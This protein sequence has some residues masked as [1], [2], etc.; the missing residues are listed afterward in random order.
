MISDPDFVPE[1]SLKG[2]TLNSITIGWSNPSEEMRDHVHYYMLIVQDNT[3]TKEAIHPGGAMNLY[4]FQDLLSA[5]TYRFKVAACSYYTKQCGRWSKEAN[6]TTMDGKSGPPQNVSLVCRFDNISR[7]SFVYVTW[8]PPLHPNGQIMDYN[9]ILEGVATFKNESGLVQNVTEIPQVKR[10]KAKSHSTRFDIIPANTNY[11][12]RVS[13]VTRGK[14]P[15]DEKIRHCR[16]PPTIPDKSKL[17]HFFWSKVEEQGRWLFKLLLPRITERNGPIC[18]YRVFLVKLEP[19]Q[20]V[21]DLP[22]P[23]EFFPISSYEEVHHSKKGGA[24]VAEMFESSTLMSEV[25]LGDGHSQNVNSTACSHCVGLRPKEHSIKSTAVPVTTNQIPTAPSTSLSGTPEN[26]FPPSISPSVDYISGITF[27]SSPEPIRIRR[28]EST[29][30][31]VPIPALI[32]HNIP[33]VSVPPLHATTE[34]MAE[35]FPVFDGQL[36]MSN[37]YTGFVEVIVYGPEQTLLPAYS[38]YF[39]ALNPGPQ[40]FHAAEQSQVLAL[41]LQ[42]LCALILIVLVL[43]LSLCLLQRYTKQVAEAQGVEMTLTNSF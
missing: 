15:G 8:T 4:L 13:G 23:E 10:V 11:T 35:Q 38:G 21:A 41:V 26:I 22:T 37:N 42:V 25:F 34:S 27:E 24:Y 6:G 28:A 19:Q 30:A 3:T 20:S 33:V 12:V 5:T 17:A 16:T 43:L 39:V 18:C 31:P 9:V 36:D 2:V 7:T 14:I 32:I 29:S 1:I 40:V